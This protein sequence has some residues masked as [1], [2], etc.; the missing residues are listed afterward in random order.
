[1]SVSAN[2]DPS[3]FVLEPSIELKKRIGAR[4]KI[5]KKTDKNRHNSKTA[6]IPIGKL[7]PRR[8]SALGRFPKGLKTDKSTCRN[9]E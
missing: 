8:R 7:K 4:K 5:Q 2:P 6:R 1:M 9:L 3:A